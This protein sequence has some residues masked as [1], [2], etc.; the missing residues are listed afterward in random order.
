[1][2]FSPPEVRRYFGVRGW[3][4]PPTRRSRAGSFLTHCSRDDAR[5]AARIR[6]LQAASRNQNQRPG[7]WRYHPAAIP[8]RDR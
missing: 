4:V 3:P 1:V 8:H 7:G 6:S 2:V 5:N